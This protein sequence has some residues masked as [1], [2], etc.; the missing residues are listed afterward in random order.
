MTKHLALTLLSLITA[1][2]CLLFFLPSAAAEVYFNVLRPA[3]YVLLGAYCFIMLGRDERTYEIRNDY[4]LISV[5]GA[6]I[7][8]IGRAHV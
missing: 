2:A 5:M 8:E 7:Y 1:A 6:L 4:L 3:F